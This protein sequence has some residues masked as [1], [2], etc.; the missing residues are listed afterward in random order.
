[1]NYIFFLP[2][3][4]LLPAVLKAIAT[5][6]FCGLPDFIS[7]LMLDEM[8]LA[9]YPFLSGIIEIVFA[10]IKKPSIKRVLFFVVQIFINHVADQDF[11]SFL[12][13]NR[14][15]EGDCRGWLSGLATASGFARAV[16][17]DSFRHQ[18]IG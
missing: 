12:F 15:S 16:V 4:L 1:L 11:Q 6:C 9:E 17:W 13:N 3:G 2:F 8:V 14:N 7:D 5:A 10:N 18:K